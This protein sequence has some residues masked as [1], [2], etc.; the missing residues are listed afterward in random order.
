ME[1][2]IKLRV[3]HPF[4]CDDIIDSKET[5][6][7]TCSFELWKEGNIRDY[8]SVVVT[9]YKY[10]ADYDLWIPETVNQYTDK[11]SIEDYGEKAFA[12]VYECPFTGDAIPIYKRVKDNC[13]HTF[14]IFTVSKRDDAEGS[15][16]HKGELIYINFFSN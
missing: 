4:K 3:A 11:E 12:R 10:N 14:S 8:K 7:K 13:N 9:R 15:E 5:V 6:E 16:I 2:K 1:Y